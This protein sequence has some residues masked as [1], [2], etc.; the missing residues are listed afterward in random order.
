MLF[1][2]LFFSRLIA[3]IMFGSYEETEDGFES[4]FSV[5]YLGHFLLTHLLLP[6]MKEASSKFNINPRIVNV[7]SVAHEVS[8]KINFN[9]VNMK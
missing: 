4:Q 6:A 2:F 1:A 7:T 3:G 5:N 8:P 9:D